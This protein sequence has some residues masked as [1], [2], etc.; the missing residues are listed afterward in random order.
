MRDRV[1]LTPENAEVMDVFNL[2]F[3]GETVSLQDMELLCRWRGIDDL[4][5]FAILIKSAERCIKEH[6]Q[7][8]NKR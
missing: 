4:E 7:K 6:N 8:E 3:M 1:V 5:K 2:L